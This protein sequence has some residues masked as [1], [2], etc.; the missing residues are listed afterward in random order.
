MSEQKHEA[1]ANADA[2]LTNAGL[3]SYTELVQL[4][5]EA[6]KLGLTFDIGSAYIRRS[7]IDKQTELNNRIKA[8]QFP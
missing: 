8:F 5:H 3:P 1:I 4:L 6:A 2:H 7:Y